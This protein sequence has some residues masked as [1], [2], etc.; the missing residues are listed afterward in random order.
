MHDNANNFKLPR[1]DEHFKIW[2]DGVKNKGLSK[3]KHT[4]NVRAKAI[5][6]KKH[7]IFTNWKNLARA[8]QIKADSKPGVN[9]DIKL[10]VKTVGIGKYYKRS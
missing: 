10:K 8:S 2:A 4:Q 3:T 7:V 5:Q 1:V 9:Y 6:F